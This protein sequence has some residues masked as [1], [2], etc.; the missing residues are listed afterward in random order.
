MLFIPDNK[1]LRVWPDCSQAYVRTAFS[2]KFQ[3]DSSSLILSKWKTQLTQECAVSQEDC[4]Q[5]WRWAA[6]FTFKQP[7][8]HLD[9]L[10]TKGADKNPSQARH[11]VTLEHVPRW[12]GWLKFCICSFED[13]VNKYR[14]ADTDQSFEWGQLCQT[15]RGNLLCFEFLCSMTFSDNKL[16]A[17]GILLMQSSTPAKIRTRLP[18][19]EFNIKTCS[20]RVFFK[21]SLKVVLGFMACHSWHDS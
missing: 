18:N 2:I 17:S 1:Q 14:G 19:N 16:P 20:E 21:F 3:V 5:R 4:T 12:Q 7:V 6:R 9:A 8:W 10:Q 15:Q 13:L 11:S